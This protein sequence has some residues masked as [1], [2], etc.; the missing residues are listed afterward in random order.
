L[1]TVVLHRAARL[2]LDEA[3]LCND[4]AAL[5]RANEKLTDERHPAAVMKSAL[6]SRARTMA[7]LM[8]VNIYR[9]LALVALPLLADADPIQPPNIVFF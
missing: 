1:I 5:S 7:Q 8:T 4:A 6:C 2:E 9:L 3:A